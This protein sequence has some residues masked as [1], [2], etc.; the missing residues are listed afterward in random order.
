MTH[1]VDF[2]VEAATTE[3]KQPLPEINVRDPFTCFIF[4]ASGDLTLRKLMPAL[5]IM[6]AERHF[7]DEFSVVGIA[8]RDYTS[9]MF[10]EKMEQ[11]IRNY[12]RIPVDEERLKLFLDRVAYHKGDISDS[13]V[14]NRLR[15]RWEQDEDWPQNRIYYLAIKPEF[16]HPVVVHLDQAELITD[17]N[18]TP[19]TRVVV[20]K[21]FGHD[22]TSAKKLNHDLLDVLDEKQIYRIDHYLGKETVQNIMSFR[23]ANSI[24]EALFNNRYV[25]H[26]QVTASETVGMESLRGAYYDATGAMRDMMQNHLLQL[27]S[28]VAMEPPSSLTADAIHSE[29]SKLLRSIQPVALDQITSQVVRAQYLDGELDGKK[30]PGYLQEERINPE[31]KTETYVGMRLH[32]DNWRWA[33][34][35]VYLRTGKRMKEKT[36]EVAVQFKMPPLQLFNTVECVGDLCDMTNA[37]P[38]ILVFRIQPDEGISLHFSAKRPAMQVVVEQVVMRFSYA[39][40]WK[41]SLPEAYERLLLDAMRGDSTLFNRTDEVEAAWGLID[42]VLQAWANDPSIPVYHYRPFTWGPE[43]SDALFVNPDTGWR[44]E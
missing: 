30:I 34:V 13:H 16:F 38:N 8:R 35:P 24:F 18:S 1:P 3:S 22:L 20:E 25:D 44:N 6:F 37:Q 36:T 7:P 19:W 40:A 11:G 2:H 29:K 17:P 23:F 32:I 15:E 12:C 28:F 39:E 5:Y 27:L 31:S 41:K 33:G 9:E 4:G 21:P 42:P 10:R 26:I 43:E 14:Y